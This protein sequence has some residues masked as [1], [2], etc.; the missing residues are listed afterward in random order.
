MRGAP[1][2]MAAA[3]ILIAEEFGWARAAGSGGENWF[4]GYLLEQGR[5]LEGAAAALW[6][7]ERLAACGDDAAAG[8]ALAQLDGHFAYVGPWRGKTL[9]AVDRMRTIPLFVAR[10]AAGA[11]AVGD[12][13]GRLVAHAALGERDV[14]AGLE[15]AMAGY[16]LGRNTLMRGLE[17]LRTG[18]MAVADGDGVRFHRYS[19]YRPWRLAPA[20]SE[21]EWR[22]DLR[23]VTL[24]VLEKLIASLRGRTV[25][26]P[27]SAGLD[28]R[29]VASGLKHLGYGNVVC[30]AY[31]RPGNHEARASRAIAERLGYP[32][33]FVSYDPAA[34][35]RMVAGERH[36]RYLRFA[37]TWCALPFLQD[38]H[39]IEELKARGLVPADAVF[40]N[41]NSGDFIS[42]GHVPAELQT[43]RADLDW[44][45][46]LEH[47]LGAQIKKHFSLWRDLRTPA[48]DARLRA[49]LMALV[50]EAPLPEHLEPEADHGLYEHLECQERQ[51]KF[52]V[53][54]QR[55]YEFQGYDWRLPLWDV[56]YLDFWEGVPLE[57]K[58]GQKLYRD[59]LMEADWGGVWSDIWPPRTVSP[60]WIRPL[61]AA[62]K[63]ACVPFGAGVWRQVDRRVFAYW[64]D[65]LSTYAV[66]GPWRRLLFDRRGFRNAVAVRCESY[67]LAKG[68][69]VDGRPAGKGA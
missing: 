62:A 17:Q 52:V 53:G 1:E 20:R 25:M 27:L 22:R 32:W 66:A 14:Q 45:A 21:A 2:I 4:K 23:D 67:L 29:L 63:L 41:G 34:V 5:P 35:R 19:H 59:M 50:A 69:G 31:G 54:G 28:S 8:A 36:A 44:P 37:D 40:I 51:A 39:A 15:M 3:D 7:H 58:A 43:P 55:V 33:H 24:A 16:V 9:A 12:Q 64:T 30:F 49:R 47:L 65:L 68:L 56:A 61:R 6:L 18:E 48:N 38:F 57:M 60:A 46:R 10:P 11:V 26:L 42:G 13:A